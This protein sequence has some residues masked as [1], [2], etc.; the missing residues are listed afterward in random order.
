MDSTNPK[1]EVLVMK[2]GAIIG[3]IAFLSLAFALLM[4]IFGG[5]S[6]IEE[7]AKKDIIKYLVEKRGI[8]VSTIEVTDQS[9]FIEAPSQWGRYQHGLIFIQKNSSGEEI[10][11]KYIHFLDAEGH[12]RHVDIESMPRSSFMPANP[13]VQKAGSWNNMYGLKNIRCADGGAGDLDCAGSH[14]LLL[15]DGNTGGIVENRY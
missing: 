11:Y 8:D 14:G 13:R 6:K 9:Y 1:P 4:M 7:Q 12:L 10:V 15:V 3:S 5:D 2:P